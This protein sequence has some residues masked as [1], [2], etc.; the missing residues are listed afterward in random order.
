MPVA[1]PFQIEP[2]FI[3]STHPAI[4]GTVS[5]A[6]PVI[7]AMIPES[8][9]IAI[10]ESSSIVHMQS[11]FFRLSRHIPLFKHELLFP[12]G[13]HLGGLLL[14]VISPA[15]FTGGV[16]RYITDT[17][18]RWL[19]PAKRL[20][21]ASGLNF[22]FQ[23][24]LYPQQQFFF[25]QEFFQFT[26]PSDL[27]LAGSTVSRLIED[28]RI[29]ILAVY[30]LRYLASLK[31]I[32]FE[33]RQELMQ[34]HLH[35][36]FYP[37]DVN[38]DPTVYDQMHQFLLKL[39]QEEKFGWIKDNIRYLMDTRPESVDRT[40]YYEI[41][42]FS[43]H[44]RTTLAHSRDSRYISRIVAF[45]Y[46]FKKALLQ[47]TKEEP[48]E[49]HLS[50]K[51]VNSQ[52][53]KSDPMLGILMGMNLLKE[54]ENFEVIHLLNAVQSCLPEVVAVE[55]SFFV[56][57]REERVRIFYVEVK[58][59]HHLSF[60]I[61][62]IRHLKQ[63]LPTL[64][65]RRVENVIH[66]IFMPRNEE[67]V[68]RNIV[69][70]SKQIKF[71][72]DLPHLTIHYE[73][74]SDLEI[75]FLIVLVR[76]LKEKDLPFRELCKGSGLKIAI[77]EI[78]SAGSLKRRCPKEAVVFRAIIDK[79][80]FFRKD[81]SL[82]LKRARQQVV[83]ELR[84]FIGEF[85]DYNGGMIHKQDEALENLRKVLGPFAAQHELLLENF[86]YSLR[87]GIM[88]TIH[89]G[90]H[91]AI[92]FKLLLEVLDEDLVQK[93][94][95][96]KVVGEGKY[97]FALIGAAATTFKEE[98]QSAVAKLKIA[99]YDLT[100]TFLHVHELATLGYILRTE[101]MERRQELQQALLEAMLNWKINFSCAVP[102]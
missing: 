30:R 49:R 72:R 70:L 69:L 48:H 83:A 92:L 8:V 59:P 58:K 60:S 37:A 80:L 54:G 98:V 87:P 102:C 96:L 65:K 42:A 78:R 25:Q 55:D 7:E 62:D 53:D 34:Q 68:L 33:E 5:T 66:P 89:T 10:R 85:R 15:E 76:L 19:V 44:F 88:Q 77:D 81:F 18:T 64:L 56:D 9:A 17:F 94:F 23:F 40:I 11:H 2:T 82:D 61:N 14:H 43:S 71:L 21:C 26:Q 20:G 75:S 46:L 100:T 50:I 41:S 51:I 91:L 12:Q 31:S 24:S 52:L 27:S 84:K 1:N 86:F 101:D 79:R 39:S 22:A 28:V 47:S 90:E 63:T 36:L 99:S 93:G 74:Q 73:K 38:A 3:S 6:E 35:S 13:P 57:R 45:H 4:R 67:E 32:P 97:F 95:S 29:N 16:G